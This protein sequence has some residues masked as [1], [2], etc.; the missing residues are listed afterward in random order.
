MNRIIRS[1]A[2]IGLFIFIAGPSSAQQSEDVHAAGSNL[3]RIG[4]GSTTDAA[5]HSNEKHY[6]EEIAN[7][8]LF[9]QY[10]SVGLRYEMDDP[11]EVG[12]SY[13]DRNFRRRWITYRKDNL[14]LQAGDVS[15]L[16]GRGLA[17]NLFESR[18]L[19]YDSWLDGVFG[20][21]EFK[22]PKEWVDLDMSVAVRGVGGIEN[23][24]PVPISTGSTLSQADTLPVKISARA[25]NGEFSF[26]KHKLTLGAVFLQAF[27]TGDLI[28]Q[29]LTESREV[30]QPDFYADLNSGEFEGY[31][32]WTENRTH[33]SEIYG[34]A[35][36]TS[37]TGHA[38]YGSLSYSN[39]N[40]GLTLEYKNYD[41][42]R[43]PN[44]DQ[45]QDVFSRLPISSP[46]EVYKDI[47]LTTISRTNHP[48]WFDD[49]LG[50][51][52]EANITAIPHWT[53]DLYGASSSRH[54][55]YDANSLAVDSTNLLP[56]F[57]DFGYYPFWEYFAEAEWNFVPDNDLDYIR[58]VLHRRSDVISYS[59]SNA[60]AETKS[61]TTLAVK[62]QYETTPSQSLLGILEH[63]WSYDGSLTT[64][65]KRRLN[66]LLT[67]QYTFGP[68]IT[69]G[70]LLDL[71]IQYENGP[72]HL[73]DNWPQ[74]FISLRLGGSHTLLASYGAER[75]GLNCTGGICRQVPPFKGLRL[76]LTSQ[77]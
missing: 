11:S 19:N 52:L 36:D 67:L 37:H 34:S 24:Y 28:S 35:V 58:F 17:V 76:T 66:E 68:T 20:K 45:F 12:R 4:D 69:I 42:F 71:S 2:A 62:T 26:F 13:Q 49:E 77:I 61:S 38:M 63:Q 70:G 57:S 72:F 14:D 40:F 59:A 75:G 44:G 9:Y 1:I 53:I 64:T 51:A 74:G 23:F 27:A 15:A 48:V 30:N 22:I 10:F 56:R 5:G 50:L 3:L 39:A 47:T 32:E 16:F 46:P 43:H 65:D 60:G 41:Y 8:R 18:P 7:A 55:K 21:T 73:E 6:L 54:D 31:L 33:V 29:G 25:V